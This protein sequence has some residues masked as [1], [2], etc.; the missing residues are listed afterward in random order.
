MPDTT[1]KTKCYTYKVEMVIQV[2]AKDST[3]ASNQL[4][5]IGGHIT[6]RKVEL[7]DTTELPV[8]S[9]KPELDKKLKP[10]L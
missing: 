6:S 4:N 9:D 2:L 1:E 8:G 3:T 5:S 7:L 10:V